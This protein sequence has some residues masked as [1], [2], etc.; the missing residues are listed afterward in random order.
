MR[1]PT[2]PSLGNLALTYAKMPV[3]SGSTTKEIKWSKPARKPT[4]Q[5]FYRLRAWN[6]R[7]KSPRKHGGLIG[8]AAVAVFN[9]MVFDCLN[10]R[11]GQLDPSYEGLVEKTGYCRA[12][13]AKALARLRELRV[14]T[15]IRRCKGVMRDGRFCL[16]QERN[17]YFINPEEYWKGYRAPLAV[18]DA[19]E[20]GTWGEHPVLL[21]GLALGAQAIEDEFSAG[22][23][24]SALTSDPNDALALALAALQRNMLNCKSTN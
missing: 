4:H 2:L 17:A 11:T 18:P 12:T 10:Y 9:A 20:P 16:E 21:T 3:W 1:L 24:Q 22:A 7:T 19:P 15:W 13:I 23:L 8:R 5:L 14:I 6:L